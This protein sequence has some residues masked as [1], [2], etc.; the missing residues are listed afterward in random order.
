MD[1]KN[2]WHHSELGMGPSWI[3]HVTHSENTKTTLHISGIVFQNGFRVLAR[4]A[5]H[6]S[7]DMRLYHFSWLASFELPSIDT[8]E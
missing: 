7:R 3:A 8:Q 5:K 6:C 2:A 4:D 1:M